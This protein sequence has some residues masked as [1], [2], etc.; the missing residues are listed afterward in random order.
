MKSGM[1]GAPG[2]GGAGRPENRVTA[3]SKL[4]QKKCTGLA[5][6]EKARA[7]HREHLVDLYQRAPEPGDLL[8][9]VGRMD[10]V[11]LERDRV[12]D[13]DRHG[14]EVRREVQDDAARPHGIQRKR[15]AT[16][17]GE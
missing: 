13:L 9:V 15:S 4:P 14:P 8:G 1:L 11:L 7:E 12:G 10:A 17:T 3:R 16:A 5:F 2:W 6:P